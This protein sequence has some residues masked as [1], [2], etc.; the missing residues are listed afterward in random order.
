VLLTT[1][2]HGVTIYDLH[3]HTSKSKASKKVSDVK[4]EELFLTLASCCFNLEETCCSETGVE[5]PQTPWHCIPAGR[6]LHIWTISTHPYTTVTVSTRVSYEECTDWNV[7][8]ESM[9]HIV[10]NGKVYKLN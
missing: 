1:R 9:A 7:Q 6:A 4:P 10:T 3:S 2:L 5:F 8:P